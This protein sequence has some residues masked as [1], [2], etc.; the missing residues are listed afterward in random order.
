MNRHF[1]GCRLERGPPSLPP[2]R[3][4]GL[5][6]PGDPAGGQARQV[7]HLP[8]GCWSTRWERKKRRRK[9]KRAFYLFFILGFS[10]EGRF[11]TLSFSLLSP[12]IKQQEIRRRCALLD[13]IHLDTA[14]SASPKWDKTLVTPVS[15]R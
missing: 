9:K 13:G 8:R 5:H 1:D 3:S 6:L 10:S 2:R 7:A 15:L 11:L 4:G 12:I 14:G